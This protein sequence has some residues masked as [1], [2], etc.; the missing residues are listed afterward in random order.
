MSKTFRFD[1][2]NRVA[3]RAV[4]AGTMLAG[5]A[6]AQPVLAE[7]DNRAS[8]ARDIDTGRA[9]RA[10]E[11]AVEE[12]PRD[13]AL[14]AAL[15]QA[16]LRDGRLA[17]ARA[18]LTEAMTLGE[19]S[20]RVALML[21]LAEIGCGSA[22]TGVMLLAQ[23][24]GSIPAADRGL[25]FALAG[26]TARGVEIISADIRAGNDNA[27]TRQNLAYAF[28]LDGRWREARMMAAQDVPADLLDQRMTEWAMNARPDQAAARVAALVGAKLSEDRGMPQ[29]LA[30]A[31]FPAPA[32]VPV[33][34]AKPKAPVMVAAAP[35]PEL[36]P[37]PA[38]A[39]TAPSK[40][41][42]K[43]PEPVV[44]ARAELPSQV[45]P[46]AVP[47]SNVSTMQMAVV[48]QTPTKPAVSAKL[49]AKP[50]VTKVAAVP[51]PGVAKIKARA[52]APALPTPSGRGTH[53]AQLG[54]YTSQANAMAGWKVFQ[55]RYANLKGQQPLIMQAKVD[56]KDYW[57]VA[58]GGFDAKGANAMCAAVKAGGF[59]CIPVAQTSVKADA[60]VR[61]AKAD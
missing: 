58:A 8:A 32:P 60:K 42:A 27:K 29:A 11:R 12:A 10:A 43:S 9:V 21:A 5:V 3:L 59:G 30:L 51:A 55:S 20:P 1:T 57:R 19:N 18:A 16:Y 46:V 45:T 36:E 13:A 7:S 39:P 54:S 26:E 25:A 38:M 35:T 50:V 44:V 37:V 33:P 17:S 61:V 40:A 41:A 23:H 22:R 15:G 52:V 24:A 49:A 4:M 47:P 31:N 2:L 14:R 28:A 48:Q 53:V 56:G 6:L 34:S